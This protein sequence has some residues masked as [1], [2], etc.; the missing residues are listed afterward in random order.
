MIKE[1]EQDK[2]KI[3]IS[4]TTKLGMVSVRSLEEYIQKNNIFR[5]YVITTIIPHQNVINYIKNIAIIEMIVY[6]NI[7]QK[8]EEIKEWHKDDLVKIINLEN[9]GERNLMGDAV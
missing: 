3:I 7:S 8:I 9:F 1:I 6:S 4:F 2:K 5:C